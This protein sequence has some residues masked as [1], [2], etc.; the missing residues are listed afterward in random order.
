MG[1]IS[2]ISAVS[3]EQTN[4]GILIF[5]NKENLNFINVAV[6]NLAPSQEEGT[7]ATPPAGA[8]PAKKKPRF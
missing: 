7:G 6:S 8:E 4:L 2:H 3:P 1:H 5:E